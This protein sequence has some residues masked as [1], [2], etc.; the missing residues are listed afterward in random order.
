[1]F[2][3]IYMATR[4]RACACIFHKTL[5]L[6]LYLLHINYSYT[7]IYVR[8]FLSIQLTRPEGIADAH[9]VYWEYGRGWSNS[10]CGLVARNHTH[11]TCTCSHLAVFAVLLPETSFQVC[12]S[13]NLINN[14]K[15]YRIAGNFRM[16][17]FSYNYFVLKSITRKLKVTKI[18]LHNNVNMFYVTMLSCMYEY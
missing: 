13:I 4:P 10:G 8:T 3:A 11:T 9:C 5:G 14:N 6:M 15:L 17:E 1:M 18:S 7:Y 16:V 12:Q 2:Y